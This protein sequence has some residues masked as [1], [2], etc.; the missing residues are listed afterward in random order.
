[1]HKL[2]EKAPYSKH[3]KPQPWGFEKGMDYLSIPVLLK[4][5][6]AAARAPANNPDRDYPST[7][8]NYSIKI[9]QVF[10]NILSIHFPLSDLVQNKGSVL[11]NCLFVRNWK[12]ISECAN[13]GFPVRISSIKRLGKK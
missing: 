10:P 5:R 4:T 6:R 3:L 12:P 11:L 7:R 13:P 1:V 8:E 9:E 2:V